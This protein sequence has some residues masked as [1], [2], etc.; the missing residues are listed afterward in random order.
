MIEYYNGKIKIAQIFF[1]ETT[2][3]PFRKIAYLK[4]TEFNSGDAMDKV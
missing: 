1:L 2:G 3:T 4:M